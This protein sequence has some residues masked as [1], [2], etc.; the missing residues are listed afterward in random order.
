MGILRRSWIYAALV[1]SAIIFLI[2]EHFT[3]I[4]FMHHLAAIPLEI[5]L[6]ALLVEKYL[7]R[8]DFLE[9][10]RQLMFIKS[11]IFRAEMR[12]LFIT[13]FGA[14]KYPKVTMSKLR[15]ANLHELKQIRKECE[16]IEYKSSEAM[17]PII[18]EYVRAHHV[19]YAFMGRSITYNFESIFQ[20]MIYILHFI[21]DVKLYIETNPE[22][23]FIYAAEKQL[24]LMEKVRKVLGDGVKKFLDYLIEL[25]EQ[26][27]SVFQEL[28]IDYEMSERIASSKLHPSTQR[29]KKKPM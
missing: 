24:L 29:S 28:M 6:G 12:N 15:H 18:M 3:H 23:L 8:K 7:E 27:P 14:L 19:W 10:K 21:Q 1:I 2:I 16:H 9:K 13:N 11:Y 22:S 4:V 25:K 17:E 5:M 26:Q 20:D